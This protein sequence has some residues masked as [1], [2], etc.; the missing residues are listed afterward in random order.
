[1]DIRGKRVL[2][3]GASIGIG[4]ALAERFAREGAQGCTG[5]AAQQML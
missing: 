5:G 1:M 4:E 2:I 3:T